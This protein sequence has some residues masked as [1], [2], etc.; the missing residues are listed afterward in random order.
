TAFKDMKSHLGL[1]PNFHQTEDR[2]DAHMF[3]SVL[4]YHLMHAIEHKLKL[5]GDSRSWW[6]IKTTLRT[7]QLIT[8]EY[9]SKDEEGTR[10]HN[11]A[12]LNSQIEPEH[13]EIY[14]KLGLSGRPLRRRKLTREIGS[15]NKSRQVSF[16][17]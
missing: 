12:R 7:H 5:A 15:D 6:T 13:L 11:T 3:I 1:R 14:T 9:I 10:Y 17:E 16:Q 2:V 4:A 8:I